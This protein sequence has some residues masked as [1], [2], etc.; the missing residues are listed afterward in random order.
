MTNCVIRQ[1]SSRVASH[2]GLSFEVLTPEFPLLPA[3]ASLLVRGI[4]DGG[5]FLARVSVRWHAA[6]GPYADPRS[7]MLVFFD[8]EEAVALAGVVVDDYAGDPRIGRL[9]HV[10][11][12]PSHRRRGIADAM[13]RICLARTEHGFRCLRLRAA[14][15]EA[16]RLYERHGFIHHPGEPDYTHLRQCQPGDDP[17][18]PSPEGQGEAMQP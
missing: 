15:A 7:V 3:V 6:D 4:A 1:S 12:L 13:V 8:G 9:K 14:T 16:G 17:G 11:V 2:A 5:A 18:G 10:Y